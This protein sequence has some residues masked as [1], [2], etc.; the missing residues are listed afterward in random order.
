[1]NLYF[2]QP[3]PNSTQRRYG[4]IFRIELEWILRFAGV[5]GD[6]EVFY[7]GRDG[8]LHIDLRK[9]VNYVRH[10]LFETYN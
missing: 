9:S 5:H 1:M 3:Q 2:L 7:Y 8:K 6:L 4:F 10:K